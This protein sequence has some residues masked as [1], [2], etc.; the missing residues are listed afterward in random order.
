M[1]L[2]QL[3][4]SVIRFHCIMVFPSR[5][6][7]Q[8]LTRIIRS[9]LWKM[10]TGDHPTRGGVP[11][12]VSEAPLS[13]GGLNVGNVDTILQQAAVNLLI[14]VFNNRQTIWAQCMME[15]TERL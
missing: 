2:S 4:A 10:Q 1:L 15:T 8:Q 6:I 12:W 9:F 13:Q 5:E 3:M 7:R 11:Q 14:R